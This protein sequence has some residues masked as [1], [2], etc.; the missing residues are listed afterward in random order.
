[1]VTEITERMLQ[2]CLKLGV[3]ADL[4]LT[5]EVGVSGGVDKND[6]KKINTLSN[7]EYTKKH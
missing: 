7:S 5:A 2:E 6:C 1:M 4:G 3:T